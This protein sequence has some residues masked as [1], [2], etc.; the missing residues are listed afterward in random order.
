MK[1]CNPGIKIG[2]VGPINPK[3]FKK[4]LYKDSI[5]VNQSNVTA[6]SV[7]RLVESYILEGYF[8][9]VFTIT[10]DSKTYIL[11]G[12][13]LEI[14]VIGTGIFKSHKYPKLNRYYSNLVCSF[15]YPK[16][17]I[18]ALNKSISDLDILHAH[19]T[20]DYA[21]AA[22]KYTKQIPVVCTVRDWAPYIYRMSNFRQKVLFVKK[23][24][25]AGKVLKNKS[26]KFVANSYY[27][28]ELLSAIQPDKD[29]PIIFNS[30]QDDA[31]LGDRNAYCCETK[32]IR[33]VSIASALNDKRKNIE[34][35]LTAFRGLLNSYPN[36]QLVLIGDIEAS[37]RKNWEDKN[38]L[39]RV[40][41]YG[42]ANQDEIFKVIDN[43]S[44]MVH[45]SLEE[46]FGNILLEGMARRIPV[47]G[48]Y[49]SGAVPQVL[50][51]GRFGILCNVQDSN[52]IEKCMKHVIENPQEVNVIVNNAIV[53]LKK[54]YVA[55]VVTCKHLK[56]YSDIINRYKDE[57]IDS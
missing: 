29:I 20:Y 32:T 13:N 27:T 33:I 34:S 28:K 26:L 1:N 30:I 5:D 2:V 55:S 50:G 57:R 54:T 39:N 41:F 51:E 10:T 19:W 48:G 21:F 11:K 36:S 4:Y 3:Y 17:L 7:N 56:L 35:L 25:L 42:R 12:E 22:S 18:N 14:V 40:A 15:L 23:K 43:S 16:K 38:L 24:I 47:I 9:R 44:F 31:I 6:N 45:P 53:E 52:D 37:T 49:K 46:T 8:V